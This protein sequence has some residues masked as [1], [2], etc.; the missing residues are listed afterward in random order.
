MVFIATEEIQEIHLLAGLMNCAIEMPVSL[1]F[2]QG[3]LQVT[4]E[5]L[6]MGLQR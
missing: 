3:E 1:P 4:A 6:G 2:S 5:G